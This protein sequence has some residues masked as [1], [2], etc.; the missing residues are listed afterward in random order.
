MA[1]YCAHALASTKRLTCLRK[2]V[3]TEVDSAMTAG[4]THLLEKETERIAIAIRREIDKCY[5]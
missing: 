1:E 2:R 5:A 3:A 4:L